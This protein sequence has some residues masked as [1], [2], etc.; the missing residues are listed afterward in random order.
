MDIFLSAAQLLDLVMFL[1]CAEEASQMQVKKL[2]KNIE[3]WKSNNY[4]IKLQL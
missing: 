3:I 1:V 2:R 4:A